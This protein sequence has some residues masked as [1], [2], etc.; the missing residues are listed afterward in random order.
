MNAPRTMKAGC[1]KLT[2]SS[3]PKAM[4]MPIATAAQKPP[5]CI[6]ESTALIVRSKKNSIAL[7]RPRRRPSAPGRVERHLQIPGFEARRIE[8]DLL[9]RLLELLDIVAG[10]SLELCEQNARLGPFA[11]IAEL[12]VA[13]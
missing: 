1:A 3:I 11:A 12:D 4:V 9:A 5:R 10:N 2:I 6:P 8:N 7:S 13:H